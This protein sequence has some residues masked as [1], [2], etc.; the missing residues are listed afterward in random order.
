MS[1]LELRQ[2]IGTLP[3]AQLD[4]QTTHFYL[5]VRG[6]QVRLV[7]HPVNPYRAIVAMVTATWG[8]AWAT[9]RWDKL[10]PAS[11]LHVVTSCLRRK[12]L[13]NALEA[14]TF[15]FEVAGLSRSAFDQIAR[16]R[17][18]VV[19]GSMG[20]R[21]N[22]HDDIDFRV[23]S[24]IANDPVKLDI[25]KAGRHRDKQDFM[26]MLANNG[27]WQDARAALPISACHRFTIAFSYMALQNFCSKRLMFN[28]QEDTVATAWLMRERVL[29]IFPLL[30]SYLRPGADWARRCTEHEGEEYGN[31]FR[32]SGRWPCDR[33]QVRED[34]TFNEACT[35]RERLMSD[36]GIYLPKGEEGLPT[37]QEGLD[38]LCYSDLQAFGAR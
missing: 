19:I 16:A 35:S 11:R 29:E 5:G 8:N 4:F 13:P 15:V 24:S 10:S 18:G 37:G 17:I 30:G 2:E 36:L 27:S 3:K 22:C 20:W 25:F 7:D 1:N 32:C 28:E 38:N 12:T 31:L 14:M 21:D 34:F 9:G 33:A 26:S 23:P 6:I